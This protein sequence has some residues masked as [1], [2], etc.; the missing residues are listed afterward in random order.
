MPAGP[1]TRP[2]LPRRRAGGLAEQ[3]RLPQENLLSPATQRRLAWEVKP[4]PSI[5]QVT[6]RLTALGARPWQVERVADAIT[7]SL[8][9]V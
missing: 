4:R 1:R 9:T 3:L 8:R 5:G 6:D 7:R 2:H